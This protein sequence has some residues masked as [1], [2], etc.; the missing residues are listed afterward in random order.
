VHKRLGVYYVL[1]MCLAMLTAQVAAAT[2]VTVVA[3]I[4]P[5]REVTV[6]RGGDIVR[7]T[8]NCSQAVTPTVI[9]ATSSQPTLLTPSI[10]RQY[11]TI[12]NHMGTVT[13]GVIYSAPTV[14][15]ITPAQWIHTRTGPLLTF[16][17]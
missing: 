10:Q 4:A 13:T 8:S 9:Q 17:A 7:I 3:I 5:V 11:Q 16:Q 14:S 12:M 15:V 6:D 1:V 2:S